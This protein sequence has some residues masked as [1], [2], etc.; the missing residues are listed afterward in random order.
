MASTVA[1]ATSEVPTVELPEDALA[2]RGHGDHLDPIAD[3]DRYGGHL[4]A[5]EQYADHL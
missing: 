5:L 3:D 4:V 1:E 2:G